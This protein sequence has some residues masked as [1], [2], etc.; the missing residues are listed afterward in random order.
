MIHFWY[1]FV[2]YQ[3]LNL[4]KKFPET[5]N[6]FVDQFVK[7]ETYFKY[8]NDAN[9]PQ[10][11]NITFRTKGE[12]YYPSVALASVIARYA[13]L[14][15]KEAL[16]KKYKMQFPLGANSKVDEFAKKFIN[17]YGLEEFDKICKKN[18]ANYKELNK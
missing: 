18:F 8:L 5:S 9:E 2:I 15:E 13:F 11:R 16:E 14:L 1:L 17:R 3:L 10:I 4:Y 6:I 12:S 7:P